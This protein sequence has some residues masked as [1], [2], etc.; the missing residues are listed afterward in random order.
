[1][2][3]QFIQVTPK[4]LE[5]QISNRVQ[6]QLSEFLEK[7]KPKEPTS[8]ITR[9]EVADLLKVDLSTIHNYCKSG[10]LQP[11]GIGARVYFKMS[12]IEKSLIPLNTKK[13]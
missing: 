9:K 12:D 8:L 5:E 6:K 7:F 3:I 13:G 10:K 1:M 2:N 11:Y 4:E